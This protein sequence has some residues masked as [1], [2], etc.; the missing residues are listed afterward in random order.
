MKGPTK[1]FGGIQKPLMEPFAVIPTP[2]RYYALLSRSEDRGY[3]VEF[4]INDLQ[5]AVFK[6]SGFG[7]AYR[8]LK[9]AGV[10]RN[11]V[12]KYPRVIGEVTRVDIEKPQPWFWGQ[13]V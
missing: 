9:Q 8:N 12:A 4:W 3:I 7:R 2:H 5:L 10:P 13:F 11:S 1:L 6:A